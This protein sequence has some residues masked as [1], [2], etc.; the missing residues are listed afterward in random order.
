[1]EK[2]SENMM[3]FPSMYIA[4]YTVFIILHI[5]LLLNK[6]RFS[7]TVYLCMRPL[8]LPRTWPW[9]EAANANK[10]KIHNSHSSFHPTYSSPHRENTLV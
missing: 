2:K 7:L 6:P 4:G 3:F 1:M 10:K 9:F 5:Y 8:S